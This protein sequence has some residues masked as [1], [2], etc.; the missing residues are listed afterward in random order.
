[1]WNFSLL[2]RNAVR[3]CIKAHSCFPESEMFASLSTLNP[4]TLMNTLA[5]IFKG[6]ALAPF[7]WDISI[8][9]YPSEVL[10]DVSL[11]GSKIE[12]T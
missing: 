8:Q 12:H 7:I 5:L 2:Y 6:K 3:L 4:E 10:S 1:M 11:N 9:R